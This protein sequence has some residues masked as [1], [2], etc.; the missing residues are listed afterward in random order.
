VDSQSVDDAAWTDSRNKT[1]S[2]SAPRQREKK[3]KAD[4]AESLKCTDTH[5][6]VS[7]A[8]TIRCHFAVAAMLL[9]G[10]SSPLSTRI[11]HSPA[12]RLPPITSALMHVHVSCRRLFRNK[13]HH[14]ATARATDSA[15]ARHN[16]RSSV[17]S[18]AFSLLYMASSGALVFQ[19]DSIVQEGGKDRGS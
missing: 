5:C 11:Y 16:P 7:A 10:V 8:T 18:R 6:R 17:T 3:A 14:P 12:T 9:V 13:R 1:P 15:N 4:S 2:R 19:A